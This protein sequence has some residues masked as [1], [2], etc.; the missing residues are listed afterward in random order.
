MTKGTWVYVQ[1]SRWLCQQLA[2][3]PQKHVPRNTLGNGFEQQHLV[4]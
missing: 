4:T 2:G 3:H 1:K